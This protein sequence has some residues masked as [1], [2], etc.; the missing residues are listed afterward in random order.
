MAKRNQFNYWI[1]LV[2][3]LLAGTA[4]WAL[5]SL[6]NMGAEDLLASWGIVNPYYQ[7]LAVFGV[8]MVLFVLTGLGLKKSLDRILK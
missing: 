8:I 4:S 6:I 1:G 2:F 3:V 5:Y 7:S